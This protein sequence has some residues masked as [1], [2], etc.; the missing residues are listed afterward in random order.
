MPKETLRMCVAC[1]QMKDKRSLIRVVRSKDD[2]MV[3]DK[4]HKLN[5]RGAYICKDKQCFEK[6]IKSK[7]LNRALKCDITDDLM[8]EIKKNL[9]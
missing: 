5:G 1:R 6:C 7:A 9:E 4:S 3:L 2:Q 8:N